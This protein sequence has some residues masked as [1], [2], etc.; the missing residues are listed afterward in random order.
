MWNEGNVG[1]LPCM[2]LAMA[3]GVRGI[4][5][6]LY[7]GSEPCMGWGMGVAMDAVLVPRAVRDCGCWNA[8]KLDEDDTQELRDKLSDV[9]KADPERE[10]KK[11]LIR[12]KLYFNM[13]IKNYII[14]KHQLKKYIDRYRSTLLKVRQ[15]NQEASL[16]FHTRGYHLYHIWK[17]ELDE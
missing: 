12:Q 4:P 15:F 14:C 2:E 13:Q 17:R 5:S 6:R 10:K 11:N 7:G 9:V 8:G 16:P 3:D 1:P